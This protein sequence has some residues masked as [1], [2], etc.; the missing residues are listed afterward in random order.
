MTRKLLTELPGNPDHRPRINS[1]GICN[2]LTEV[3]VIRRFQLVFDDNQAVLIQV[4]GQNVNPE[5]PYRRFLFDR[6]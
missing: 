3:V 2:Q 5:I 1:S 4:T 6:L